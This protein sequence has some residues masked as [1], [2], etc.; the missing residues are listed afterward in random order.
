MLFFFLLSG[1]SFLMK[2]TLLAVLNQGSSSS[3]G[4]KRGR[5]Y[6]LRLAGWLAGSEQLVVS[7]RG[8]KG[9]ERLPI[10]S[11]SLS[12]SLSSCFLGVLAAHPRNYLS[13]RW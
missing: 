13:T 1:F 12:V 9:R 3:T 7:G 4:E 2:I 5:N 6:L 8:I 10:N 11:S